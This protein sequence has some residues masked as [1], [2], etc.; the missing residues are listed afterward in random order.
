MKPLVIAAALALASATLVQPVA[1]ETAPQIWTTIADT[2]PRSLFE[3][4]NDS[5]PRSVFDQIRDSAPRSASS[6]DERFVGE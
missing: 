4:L 2:A 5:A 3:E 6:D 1:A